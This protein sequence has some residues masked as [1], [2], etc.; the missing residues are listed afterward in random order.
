MSSSIAT[1]EAEVRRALDCLMVRAKRQSDIADR[2]EEIMRLIDLLGKY[3]VAKP[4]EVFSLP[5]W[6]VVY[7]N[8][9]SRFGWSLKTNLKTGVRIGVLSAG[10]LRFSIHLGRMP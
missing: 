10:W 4:R 1:E 5:P 7:L 3:L 8:R 2:L 9:P 6:V